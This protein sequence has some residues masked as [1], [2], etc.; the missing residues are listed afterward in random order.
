MRLRRF[1]EKC[2]L[3][4]KALGVTISRGVLRRRVTRENQIGRQGGGFF[5]FDVALIEHHPELRRLFV[6]DEVNGKSYAVERDKFD[7]Y[8]VRETLGV[9]PQF[10]LYFRYWRIDGGRDES[11]ASVASSAAAAVVSWVQS[12]FV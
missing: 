3:S 5:A 2:G 9:K 1:C 8:A 12:R 10:V 6:R 11:S 4:H 7:A